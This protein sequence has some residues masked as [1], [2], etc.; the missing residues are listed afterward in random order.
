MSME[1]YKG[2][3]TSLEDTPFGYTLSM[4]GGKWRLVIL[5]WLAEQ[6]ATRFNELRRRIGH[7]TEKTLSGQLKELERDGLVVRK[8]YPQIPPKVEYSLSE[9]GWSLYPLM[10]TMCAWGEKHRERQ[11]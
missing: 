1:Q 4:I 9:K 7:I 10:E 3:I 11:P 6:E 8:E 2:R 5:Y